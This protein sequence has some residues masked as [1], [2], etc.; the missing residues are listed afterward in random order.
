[1]N[2]SSSSAAELTMRD[3]TAGYYSHDLVLN[4]VTLTA[5]PGKVTVLLGPNGSG[6]STALRVLYGILKPRNGQV[7]LDGQD[8]TTAPTHQRPNL[9]IALLPQGRS[10]FSELTVQENLEMGGWTIQRDR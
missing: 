5:L 10:V 7:L 1:M 9:G 6:K 2:E 8:I 3:I 4:A